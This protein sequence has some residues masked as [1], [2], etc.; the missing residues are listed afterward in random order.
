MVIAPLCLP[1]DMVITVA[2]L[3]NLQTTRAR[4]VW[5]G[6]EQDGTGFKLGLE[7]LDGVDFWGDDYNPES[8]R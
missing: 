3:A 8:S 4:V 2:N 7:F 1:D 6:G 5:S